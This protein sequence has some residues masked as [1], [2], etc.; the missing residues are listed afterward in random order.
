MKH[1]QLIVCFII[2][3]IGSITF[4]MEH[5]VE[6]Q[7]QPINNCIT[8]TINAIDEKI[9]KKYSKNFIPDFATTLGLTEEEKHDIATIASACCEKNNTQLSTQL[10]ND[11]RKKN[12]FFDAA[13]DYFSD[14]AH[15]N[16]NNVTYTTIDTVNNPA[17]QQPIPQ[18]NTIPQPIKKYIIKTVYKEM[19]ASYNIPLVHDRAVRLFAIH[20]K[21]DTVASYC[22][23]NTLH[24]WDLKTGAEKKKI[25]NHPNIDFMQFNHDGSLIALISNLL[26][27]NFCK[28]SRIQIRNSTT[29]ERIATIKQDNHVYFANFVQ[30][31]SNS[32]IATFMLEENSKY[33]RRDRVMH[34][35]QLNEQN[36]YIHIGSLPPLP[37]LGE[38][39]IEFLS[40]K[41]KYEGSLDEENN[42]VIH[43]TAKKCPA[44]YLCTQAIYNHKETNTRNIIEQS[45]TYQQL[46]E[47][48]KQLVIKKYH[49]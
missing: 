8:T 49:K 19:G 41:K 26:T 28:K 35:W 42:R 15:Q 14:F 16:I 13:I 11:L 46:T 17:N 23:G 29:A 47:Y 44:L 7:Q 18:L 36:K 33:K 30:G 45:Q 34:L 3:S 38:H 22:H 24:L 32:T 48:E 20:P 21:S 4:A 25:V 43:I 10:I 31:Q 9:N 27:K 39:F 2:S 1:I 37:W 40:D 5:F 6:L 12:I